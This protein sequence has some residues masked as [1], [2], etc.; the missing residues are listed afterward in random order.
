MNVKQERK[1]TVKARGFDYLAT[2][3]SPSNMKGQKMLMIE[4]NMWFMKPGT[5]KPVPISPRQKLVGAAAIGDIAATDYTNEYNATP[6]ADEMVDGELCYVF[7]LKAID[8]KTTY[9]QIKYWI[10]QERLVGVKAEYFTVS[11]KLFKSARFDYKN[12]VQI[13]NEPHPFISKMVITDAL[14]SK[15]ITTLTFSD[16]NLVKV[17]DSTFDLNLI[18]R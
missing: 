4:R 12:Q 2:M 10:S 9:D 1:L 11:G 6:L 14:I 15:N 17:P 5:K 16:P 18:M 13:R 7:D 8:K 3:T